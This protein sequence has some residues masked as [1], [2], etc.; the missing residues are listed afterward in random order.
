MSSFLPSRVSGSRVVN[1]VTAAV[2][3]L[4]AASAVYWVLHWPKAELA[5]AASVPAASNQAT[6]DQHVPMARALGQAVAQSASP[7]LQTSSAY[8]LVGVIASPSGQGSALIAVDG[9]PPKAYKVG[10]TVQDGWTLAS[11]TARQARLKSSGAEVLLELPA[12]DKP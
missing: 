12:T 4:A 11:L 5:I 1:V 7:A 9:Q 2:W 3:T 8:K 6:A 10:Q